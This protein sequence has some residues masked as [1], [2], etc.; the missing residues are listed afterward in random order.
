MRK[1]VERIK[2]DVSARDLSEFK[3]YIEY[4]EKNGHLM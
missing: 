2:D 4:V 3:K 1:Q